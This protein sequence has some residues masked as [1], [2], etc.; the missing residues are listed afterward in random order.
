MMCVLAANTLLHAHSCKR[1][2][3]IFVPVTISHIFSGRSHIILC[4]VSACEVMGAT[5]CQAEI[6]STPRQQHH[7]KEKKKKIT[8]ELEVFVVLHLQLQPT[9]PDLLLCFYL[10]MNFTL[11]CFEC[12]M[13]IGESTH[14]VAEQGGDSH[15]GKGTPRSCAIYFAITLFS[16]PENVY[17]RVALTNMSL[18]I[19]VTLDLI[20]PHIFNY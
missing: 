3:F 13:Q 8:C 17:S 16:L 18:P 1:C 12:Y 2:H 7:Q 10:W 4:R 14:G 9:F 11:R 20:F 19:F 6:I 15:C 5:A